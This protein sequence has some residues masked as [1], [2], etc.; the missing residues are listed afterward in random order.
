MT[1]AD[2]LG[3][4]HVETVERDGHAELRLVGEL[5]MDAADRLAQAL[6]PVF[7]HGVPKIVLNL[8]E[9]RFIDSSGLRQLF[10]ALRHQRSH[11]GDV[12]LHAPSAATLR[13]L[14]IVGMTTLFTIT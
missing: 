4:F 10:L 6:R 7:D 8:S 13:V 9:L 2:D 5:D 3:G 11:G 12:V 14:D 1:A